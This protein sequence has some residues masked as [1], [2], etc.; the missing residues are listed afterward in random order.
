MPRCR[1]AEGS[2]DQQRQ[3]VETARVQL[4][5][6]QKN[7]ARQRDLW[8][9][10]LTTRE[11]LDKAENDVKAAES[12]LREREKQVSFTGGAH[13]PGTGHPRERPLRPEQGAHRVADRRHRD[14]PQH[15]GR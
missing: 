6:A 14:A 12:S 11:A 9:Q 15:P 1:P 13:R 10:Q 4:D 2:L 5:Q 8:K 7:L 3:A